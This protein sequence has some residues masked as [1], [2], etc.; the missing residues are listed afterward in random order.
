MT[1][2]L[3]NYESPESVGLIV[4]TALTEFVTSSVLIFFRYF[5]CEFYAL[6]LRVHEL[7]ELIKLYFVGLPQQPTCLKN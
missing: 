6:H 7:N 2:N 4:L 1:R 5:C 3:C